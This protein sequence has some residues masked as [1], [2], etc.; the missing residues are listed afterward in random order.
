MGN[1]K[2]QTATA[3]ATAKLMIHSS[4][5]KASGSLART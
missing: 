5:A 3:T 4:A 2:K 1:K